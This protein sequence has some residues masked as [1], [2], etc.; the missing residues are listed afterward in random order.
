M[1]TSAWIE[2]KES[3]YL[4]ENLVNSCFEAICVVIGVIIRGVD[5][6]WLGSYYKR[7]VFRDIIG[8]SHNSK[9]G[10]HTE[11]AII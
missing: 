2:K 10:K 8:K 9:I 6:Q 5:F 3:I 11:Q 7:Y 4:Q 1:L